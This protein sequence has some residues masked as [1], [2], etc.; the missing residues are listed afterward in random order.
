MTTKYK[1]I[2]I[3]NDVHRKLRIYCAKTGDT[4]L[5]F[6]SNAVSK[7]LCAYYK[8]LKERRSNDCHSD[9]GSTL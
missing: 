7:A 1:Y 9:N 5:V 4:A 2:A 8:N 3:H 6:A